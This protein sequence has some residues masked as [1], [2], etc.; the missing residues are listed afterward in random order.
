MDDTT[1]ASS[2]FDPWRGA[3]RW[4]RSEL[5]RLVWVVALAV[6]AVIGTTFLNHAFERM[7]FATARIWCDRGVVALKAGHAEEAVRDLQAA[8]AH[9]RDNPQY[10]LRL[11][12][13]LA[14][15]GK[16]AQAKAY[17]LN[18][19]Q[20]EPGNGELNLQLARL[21]VREHNPVEAQQYYHGAIFGVWDSDAIAN[22]RAARQEL[23]DF[24][25][26]QNRKQDAEAELIALSGEIPNDPALRMQ[27]GELFLR[28]GNAKRALAE[29][30]Q[31]VRLDAR[32]EKALAAAGK[33]AFALGDF[34]QA[35]SYLERAVRL[36]PEDASSHDSL[37]SVLTV[38]A[39]NPFDRRLRYSERQARAMHAFAV[40]GRRLQSCAQAKGIDLSAAGDNPLQADAAQWKKLKPQVTPR[41]LRRNPDLMES[42]AILA[43]DIE[44]HTADAC[45]PP[46]GEDL[47]LLLV[48][49]SRGAR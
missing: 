8:L 46:A 35:Q 42:A 40:A 14:E 18:L 23:I 28:A 5:A 49:Q 7:Q 30:Q 16:T 26:S 39:V 41:G 3:R 31:A 20:A 47:A 19:W 25:L 11:A 29:F 45:G 27:V 33:T 36:A 24:L 2:K 1:A 6:A 37:E 21:A 48:A 32:G 43:L 9:D 13:A 22:R 44:R 15:A 34:A 4:A 17:F 38:E 12:Q 10:I